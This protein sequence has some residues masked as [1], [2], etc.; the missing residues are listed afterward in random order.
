MTYL[1]KEEETV[2]LT[3]FLLN[4]TVSLIPLGLFQEEFYVE[5]KFRGIL[6][7]TVKDG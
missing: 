4:E 2:Y 3:F 7:E 6:N 5:P 1:S